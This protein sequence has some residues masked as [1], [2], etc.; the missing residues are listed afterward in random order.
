[1]RDIKTK[2]LYLK[3]CSSKD[4][5]MYSIRIEDESGQEVGIL[6]IS[7]KNEISYYI[8]SKFEGNRYAEEALRGLTVYFIKEQRTPKIYAITEQSAYIADNCAYVSKDR[9]NY[10]M[11]IKDIDEYMNKIKEIDI[12]R[13]S[14]TEKEIDK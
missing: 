14:K 1:M 2:R 13:K 12:K 4:Y 9:K 7:E 6:S 3:S 11:E 5:G 10:K 8:D